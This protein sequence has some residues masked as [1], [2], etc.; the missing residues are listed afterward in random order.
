MPPWLPEPQK[1]KFADELRL[2]D[3]EIALILD[4]ARRTATIVADT[5]LRCYGL[6]AWDFRPLAETNASV[7]WKLAQA[8]AKLY[9][10]AE[11]RQA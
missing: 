6:T 8:M 1:L 7:S 2:A 5:D 10:A 3:G 4:S 11:E 9:A